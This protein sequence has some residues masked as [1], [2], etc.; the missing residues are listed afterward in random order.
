ML[1]NVPQLITVRPALILFYVVRSVVLIS[2]E[3]DRF[4]LTLVTDNGKEINRLPVFNIGNILWINDLL[5][6]V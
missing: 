6:N 1:T 2:L 5:E 3:N 4:V